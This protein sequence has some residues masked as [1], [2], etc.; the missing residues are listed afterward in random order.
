ME[1]MFAANAI[2]D[3][4]FSFARRGY[5]ASNKISGSITIAAGAASVI[6]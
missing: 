5:V 6:G 4:A 1:D 2:P 3:G